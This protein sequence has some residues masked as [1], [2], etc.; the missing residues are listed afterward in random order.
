MEDFTARF[1]IETKAIWE[2]FI[3]FTNFQYD[4]EW[5]KLIVHKVPTKPFQYEEGPNF[6]KE[7][8]EN[9]NNIKLI[10]TPIWLS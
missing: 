9:F 8:I 7:D 2:A 4:E 3:P 1:L 6:L 5:I 10:R